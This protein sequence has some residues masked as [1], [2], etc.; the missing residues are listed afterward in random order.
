MGGATET[1][2][3]SGPANGAGSGSS[4]EVDEWIGSSVGCGDANSDGGDAVKVAGAPNV[5][6][7]GWASTS[8]AFGSLIASR[9]FN[10]SR[11]FEREG[12]VGRVG[13]EMALSAD[14]DTPGTIRSDGKLRASAWWNGDGS[15]AGDRDCSFD[16]PGCRLW[17]P[18]NWERTCWPNSAARRDKSVAPEV[19]AA[20][21]GSSMTQAD[22]IARC[23]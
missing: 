2:P 4:A 8:I 11:G 9:H 1:E 19:G 20:R 6:I 18:R 7:A 22:S 23:A 13:A 16:G 21:A 15:I 3:A 17:M 12:T 14:I 10:S 5:A